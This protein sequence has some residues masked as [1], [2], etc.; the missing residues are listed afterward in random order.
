MTFAGRTI[1]EFTCDSCL[2]AGISRRRC[3]KGISQAE[4]VTDQE[5]FMLLIRN[6]QWSQCI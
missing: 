5:L 2:S 4:T 3:V 1:A 6:L